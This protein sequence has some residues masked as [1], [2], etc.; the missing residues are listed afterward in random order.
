MKAGIKVT[1]SLDKGTGSGVVECQDILSLKIIYLS[2]VTG[3]QLS[4]RAPS[5]HHF[6]NYQVVSGES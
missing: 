2:A 6:V 1:Q 4:T 3:D 5:L